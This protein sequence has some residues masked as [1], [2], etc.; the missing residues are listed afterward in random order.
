MT[1]NLSLTN[2]DTILRQS[3]YASIYRLHLLAVNPPLISWSAY[4]C[5]RVLLSCEPQRFHLLNTL[6]I[7][8]KFGTIQ[9]FF[10]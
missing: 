3:P 2:N 5:T 1:V 10:N 8:L 6:S 4:V 7:Q 9:K